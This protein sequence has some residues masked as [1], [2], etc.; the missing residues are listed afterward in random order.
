MLKLGNM[1]TKPLID[2]YRALDLTDE[3]GLLCGRVLGDLGVDVIKVEPPGGD[4]ARNIGPFYNNI[5]DPEK[6]LFWFAY[7]ANKRSITLNLHSQDSKKLFQSL[8]EKSDFVIESFPPGFMKSLGLDYD[9]LKKINPRIIVA[10]ITPFG[11]TGP[12]RDF[13]SCDLSLQAAGG[14]VYIC[15]D[16]DLT[17]VR[18]TAEQA[19]CHA[20]VQ[21]AAASLI[22]NYSRQLTGKGQHID[23]SIQ[24]CILWTTCY[25]VPRWDVTK[26][27]FPRAGSWQQRE[28]VKMRYLYPCKDGYVCY[29]IGIADLMGPSQA[30]LVQAMN[31]EGKGEE[32]KDIDWTSIGVEEVTQEDNDRWEKV[33]LEYFATHT[34][35]ELMNIAQKYEIMLSAVNTTGDMLHDSQFVSRNYWVEVA[36]SELEAKVVYPGPFYQSNETSWDI[37]R[38]PPLI[39][40]HNWEIYGGE[41]GISPEEL[42]RL[43]QADAI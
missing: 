30:R 14:L 33:M 32:L 20:G 22:A 40:E 9:S 4:P 27:L 6:S 11:Q 28:H 26:R 18:I 21:A 2:N 12:Y 24:E 41:M 34:K 37:R 3:K 17:P 29:R 10:S 13:T 19:Y 7:N 43:K 16:T 25:T 1:A 36:H 42:I 5:P 38:R 35:E 39:G 31:K 23:L 8:V 15:G